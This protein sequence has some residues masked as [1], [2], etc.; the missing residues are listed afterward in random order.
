MSNNKT[1]KNSYKKRYDDYEKDSGDLINHFH[2]IAGECSNKEP[3]GSSDALAIYQHT[4]DEGDVFYDGY[5]YSCNQYFSKEHVHNSSLAVELGIK[6]GIVVE[7]KNFPTK[8]KAE[9]LTKEFVIDFI[10]KTGYKSNNYRGIRDEI[11]QFF[12]HL[13]KLD[14]NGNVVSRYYP[15][16][17]DGSV[18][19][20]KHRAHPKDFRY[21]KL[22]LT[23]I[24]SDLSGEVKFK[25]GGKW[26]LITG[27][28]EDKAAAYQMLLDAHNRNPN[29]EGLD[30]PAV[31]S[32]TT[33]EPSGYKQLAKRY[34]F[35]DQ[36]EIIVLGFDNDESGIQATQDAIGVL[37][38][39]KV[40]IAT[41]SGKDPNQM[42]LDGREK[43]FV[44]DFYNAKP[45]VS[46]G[47]KT[48]VDAETEVEEFLLAPKIPLPF[49]MHKMQKMMRGGIKTTGAIVNIIGQTS[50]GKTLV[51]D[52]LL[53]HWIFNSPLKPTI[54][55][56]ERTAGEL[57]IDLYSL[58]LK[59]NLVYFEDGQ[60]AVDYLHLPEV[61]DLCNTLR[62]DENGLP[63]F[64]I[65]DE[66]S[67]DINLMKKQVDRVRKQYGSNFLI[68]DPL[69]DILRS[70]PLDIQDDFMMYQKMLKKDG[71]V[72][73]N[74]MH[75]R[76]TQTDKEGKSKDT[77]EYDTYG[78][79]SF[80]QSA[81]INIVL[82][83]DKV[84]EDI[85]EKNTTHLTMPKC[86]GGQT[87]HAGDL[88]FD[89]Q[90]RQL[91]DKEDY[92]N[93]NIEYMNYGNQNNS[94]P[95][96]SYPSPESISNNQADNSADQD[97]GE[98]VLPAF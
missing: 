24:D 78:S 56:I 15:E 45:A 90:S 10:K 32:V 38:E 44:R 60:S 5:C 7:K 48:S 4:T 58:H 22:G 88:Y 35:C 27:G 93:G 6:D 39:D 51:T 87:G 42:L 29:N 68:T 20:Y 49:C 28:C 85:I 95:N 57:L 67:G 83:R 84:A 40:R 76:K 14:K 73:V 91:Y 55:S 69:T 18:T 81:D 82:N 77:T 8:P 54:I 41:W 9:P 75:T 25:G 92:F 61:K 94:V 66:R 59:K 43:Q 13:T 21:G 1:N 89:V 34:D 71:M 33:G 72:L 96:I 16:T 80:V 12:G 97:E 79:S 2:C 50:I 64:F 74:V 62:Y 36:Y 30:P 37:P 65:I 63:R 46:L 19:G 70:S 98:Q 53:Y 52:I 26:L 11:S 17:R 23:G 3:C 47:I 31:V 86:R